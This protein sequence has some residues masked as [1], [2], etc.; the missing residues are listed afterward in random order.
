MTWTWRCPS[1]GRVLDVAYFIC[2]CGYES[3]SSERDYSRLKQREIDRKQQEYERNQQLIRERLIG[4]VSA[5]NS[6]L[7]DLPKKIRA[8]EI[9]LDEAV[10]EFADGAFAPFWD[11]V[12]RVAINIAHF[13]RGL[14]QISHLSVSYNNEQSKIDSPPPFN[15][16]FKLIPSP[17]ITVDRMRSIVRLAQKDFHFATI[18]EQR[19]TNKLLVEGFTSLGQA[20]SDMSYRISDSIEALSCSISDL[21]KSSRDDSRQLLAGVEALHGYIQSDAEARRN[22]EKMEREMLDNIQRHRKPSI[23]S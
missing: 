19:K 5:V 3:N 7:T 1:C 21:A 15:I 23:F 11:A 6:T 20:L 18:Y 9:A 4:Y 2:S 22:H 16:D 12:E 17:T 8:A 14:Q 13:D 10:F